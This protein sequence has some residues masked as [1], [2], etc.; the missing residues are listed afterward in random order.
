MDYNKI[1]NLKEWPI[2]KLEIMKLFVI[3][4]IPSINNT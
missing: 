3:M 2:L 4:N 1:Q